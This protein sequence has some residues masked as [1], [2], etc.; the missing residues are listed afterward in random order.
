MEHFDPAQYLDL[1]ERYRV[2]HSQMV[3]TMFSRLLKLPDE[4]RAAA[5]MSSLE[6]HRPRRRAVPGA[7][8]A[9]R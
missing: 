6:V 3:P 2:T 8:E 5:D 4:V 7:G 9:G 1:V